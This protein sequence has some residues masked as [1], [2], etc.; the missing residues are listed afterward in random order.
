M[1]FYTIGQF[2]IFLWMAASGLVIGAWYAFLAFVRRLLQAGFWLSLAADLAF[3]TGAA[4]IF[5]AFL[6]AANYG[7]L[8]L[9]AVLGMLAGCALFAFGLYPPLNALT[10]ALRRGFLRAY[11]KLKQNRLINVILR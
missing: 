9:F 1:L 10:R 7:R 4:A 6:V 2:R 5:L 3:G 8:R 11:N